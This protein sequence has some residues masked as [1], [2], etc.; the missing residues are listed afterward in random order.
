M[1]YT[2]EHIRIA[3][4][5]ADF[6]HIYV[7]TYLSPIRFKDQFKDNYA[8]VYNFLYSYAF[9]RYQA[10]SAFYR[11]VATSAIQQV[12]GGVLKKITPKEI[13]E[14]WTVCRKEARGRK[15]N[16]THFPLKSQSEPSSN[17]SLLTV[18]ME[19][20]VL[21]L[22][23]WSK[24]RLSRGETERAHRTLKHVRGIGRKITSFYLR[25]IA[26]LS[27]VSEDSIQDL[28][29]LQ[30]ID[31][32]VNRALKEVIGT[33]AGMD[34]SNPDSNYW[35]KARTIVDLCEHAEC[36]ASAFNMGAWVLGSRISGSDMNFRR[37]LRDKKHKIVAASLGTLQEK[38]KRTRNGTKEEEMLSSSLKEV[39]SD[40]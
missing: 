12:F 7:K 35:M 27:K 33:K 36:S 4:L 39:L 24:R 14:C 17:R 26:F 21:N 11:E 30:P 28:H 34:F 20:S 38:A 19:E 2:K 18:M 22:A 40:L 29:L 8:S 9:E 5:L 15:L 10:P 13:R 32:W 3:R 23:T 1:A 37:I 6:S 31:I 16:A 25:D